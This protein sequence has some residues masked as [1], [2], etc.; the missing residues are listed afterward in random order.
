MAL[1]LE[2][3]AVAVRNT[4]GQYFGCK[5]GS[6]TWYVVVPREWR[7]QLLQEG[8]CCGTNHMLLVLARR[9]DII[10]AVLVEISP[11][12]KQR[13]LS[14]LL[15]FS[16]LLRWVHEDQEPPTDLR[17]DFL[18]AAVSHLPL[19]RAVRKHIR[20]HGVLRPVLKFKSS[21]ASVYSAIKG[22]VDTVTQL[23]DPTYNQ[24][25][26]VNSTTKKLV[27]ALRYVSC[28]AVNVWRLLQ[29]GQGP[30]CGLDA[31][32]RRRSKKPFH[33]VLEDL[34]MGLLLKGTATAAA[35]GVGAQVEDTGFASAGEED[36]SDYRVPT[37]K[38]KRFFLSGPGRHMRLHRQ[39]L[40]AATPLPKNASGA[41]TQRRCLVCDRKT[42]R[43][44]TLC[45]VP[46][47]VNDRSCWADFHHPAYA[48]RP[49]DQNQQTKQQ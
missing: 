13:Y 45:Q 36:F 19:W 5:V 48:G 44:C 16:R 35:M 24:F 32:R 14:G 17:S 2:E 21:V 9:G 33:N 26:K 4:R 25:I 39:G 37:R 1:H 23:M 43:T 11:T 20:Q 29:A 41:R 12:Q 38:I 34:V 22:G 7:G 47:C 40:H 46:L 31:F 27:H 10:F 18:A 8:L 30:W 42:T 49:L 28:N 15:K 3:A 6:R